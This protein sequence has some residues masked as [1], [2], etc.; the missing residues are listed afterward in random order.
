MRR[1]A[2]LKGSAL[3]QFRQHYSDASITKED[4]FHYIYALLH[5]PDYRERYDENLKRELPRIALAPAFEAFVSAGKELA[6]LHLDYES[7]DPWP[8]EYI[9]R[10][11]VPFSERVVKMK[12]SKDRN[13]IQINDSLT[14]A[15]IPAE[16][17]AYR[18]G[19]KSAVEWIID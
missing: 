4:L 14:L 2:S 12:L 13:S 6:H 7:L 16:A 11:E 8:L 19:L 1:G 9:E 10:K 5:H 3:T 18:L 15:G 17:F